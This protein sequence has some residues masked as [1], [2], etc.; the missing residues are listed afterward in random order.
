MTDRLKVREALIAWNPGTAEVAVGP[1]LRDVYVTDWTTPYLCTG[2]A[3]WV[4]VRDI[5]GD[6]ARVFILTLFNRLVL[7]QKCDLRA[8][9]TAFLGIE[10]YYALCGDWA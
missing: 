6:P 10:E 5:K 7:Q 3:A 1:L 4:D 2:G 9:H 8:V